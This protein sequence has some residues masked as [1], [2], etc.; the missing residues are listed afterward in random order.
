MR[1]NPI[2]IDDFDDDN[3]VDVENDDFQASE[4]EMGRIGIRGGRCERKPRGNIVGREM[5]DR[6]LGSIKIKIPSF[7]GRND[8]EAYLEWEKKI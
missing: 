2:P 5:V 7:Q 3:E 8:P 1:H 4:V 6:N